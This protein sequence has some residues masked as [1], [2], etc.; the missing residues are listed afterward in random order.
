M[1][2]TEN[3]NSTEILNQEFFGTIKNSKKINTK[4]QK[5]RELSKYFS[6]IGDSEQPLEIKNR[7]PNLFSLLLINLNE[8]NNNYVLAQME[9]I[10]ILGKTLN[11]DDNYK[12]FIKQCLPKLFDKFYLGNNKNR[13]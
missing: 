11:N 10:Q 6:K 13:E 9:L 3:S 5:I 8:N 12:T 2:K 7:I 1:E 4:N